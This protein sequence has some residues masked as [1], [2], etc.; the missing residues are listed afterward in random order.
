MTIKGY[1]NAVVKALKSVGTYNASLDMQCKSLASALRTL[2]IANNEIDKLDTVAVLRTTKHGQKLMPHPAFKIQRDA[3]DSIT[4]QMKAL[5]L[6]SADVSKA[7]ETDPFEDFLN[8]MKCGHD[9][10]R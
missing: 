1:F 2:E 9:D 10:D 7:T 5:G 8:T 6:T 3:Q 4:K